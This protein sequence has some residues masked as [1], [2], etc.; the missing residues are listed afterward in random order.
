MLR[1]EHLSKS[2]GQHLVLEDV[3]AEIA[4]GEVICIVGPSGCGKSTL[5][6]CLNGLETPS[7]GKIWFKG[8]DLSQPGVKMSL[9]RQ[10]MNM[11]FQSFNLYAHLSVLDNLTLA[12]VKLKGL[13]PSAASHKA[14]GLLDMVG[15]RDWAHHLPHELSGGQKQRVAIARCLAMDPEVILMDEPTSALDP[16]MVSE[17]LSVIRRL[18]RKGLTLVIVTH[19]M[20][21][22]RE[23][24]SRVFYMDERVIYE[25]GPPEQIFEQPQRPKTRAFVQRIRTFEARLASGEFD[26]FAL[27]GQAERFCEKH[28][29]SLH[30]RHHL[31]LFLEEISVM[32]RPHVLAGEA[33]DFV[34]EYAEVSRDLM[35]RIDL[36]VEVAEPLQRPAQDASGQLEVKMVRALARDMQWSEQGERIRLQASLHL[37]P[38]PA[39]V[40]AAG[41]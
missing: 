19:E 23:V 10:S 31:C 8:Q 40:V 7:G 13:S 1:I 39:G 28:A 5:L 12:P 14:L 22:A 32:L 17:V 18:A 33:F 20:A 38:L 25:Q 24:S 35:A 36:P 37:G 29:L 27:Q 2:Y 15:L 3:S 9:V 4:A 41:G 34:V 6:R 26:L 16:T 30:A 11:V 21:F